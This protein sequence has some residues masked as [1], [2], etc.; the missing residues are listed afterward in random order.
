MTQN[1]PLACYGRVVEL[2]MVKYCRR[3]CQTR[4]EAA[5]SSRPTVS[6]PQAQTGQDLARSLDLQQRQFTEPEPLVQQARHLMGRVVMFRM[7]NLS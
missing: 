5:S 7:A 1:I 6:R 2:R 4:D 3:T